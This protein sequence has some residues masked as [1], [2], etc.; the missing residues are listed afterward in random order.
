M[1]P[2]KLLVSEKRDDLEI[3]VLRII[4]WSNSREFCIVP[5]CKREVLY[6]VRIN[7]KELPM[8]TFGNVCC[9]RHLKAIYN[10]DID[11]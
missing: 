5:N 4:N 2:R 6:E 11:E 9:R 3:E 1:Q 10:I 8:I 7:Q